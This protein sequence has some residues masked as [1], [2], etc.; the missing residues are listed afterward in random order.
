MEN[1]KRIKDVTK[2][3][4]TITVDDQTSEISAK[5]DYNIPKL[6]YK[7]TATLTTKNVSFQNNQVNEATVKSLG[8][9]VLKAINKA[10]EKTEQYRDKE[11]EDTIPFPKIGANS[12][13][14]LAKAA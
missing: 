8:Q 1:G 12:G 2:F 7:I 11:D 4:R 3:E 9:L 5:L 10:I 14:R 13:D 6:T